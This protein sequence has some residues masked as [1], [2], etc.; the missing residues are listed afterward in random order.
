MSQNNCLR[1]GGEGGR[2]RDCVYTFFFLISPTV[3]VS[4]VSYL[5][6]VLIMLIFYSCGLLL[7]VITL[8]KPISER[9]NTLPGGNNCYRSLLITLHFS[10][11]QQQELRS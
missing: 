11:N 6:T 10:S 8:I 2:G 1:E 9:R 5:D 4:F 7:L 3:P